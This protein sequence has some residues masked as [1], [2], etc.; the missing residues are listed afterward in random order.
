MKNFKQY[1]RAAIVF[2]CFLNIVSCS[3]VKMLKTYSVGYQS[4]RT[5]HK[6]PDSELEIPKDAEIVVKY[7]ISSNGEL[8]VEVYNMTSSIMIIDQTLSFFVNSDGKSI[9]YFDPTVRT[10]TT[11][12]ITSESSSAAINLGS[13]TR[14]FGIGGIVGQIA[15]GISLGGSK[16]GG[17]VTTDAVYIADQP[18]VSIGPKGSIILSKAFAMKGI[19]KQ[20]LALKQNYVE[21]NTKENI[22]SNKFSVT[23]SYSLDNGVSYKNIIS[24]FFMNSKLIY[25]V[26]SHGDVNK[27]LSKIYESKP[28]CLNEKW[29]MIYFNDNV[30]TLY[31]NYVTGI[32]FD[33]Q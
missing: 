4:V 7:A 16:S 25:Q 3:P 2:S 14:A 5:K 8:L 31:D 27:A 9:S 29:W 33:Y 12:Q 28:D 11:Q 6:Q 17:E 10:I 15:G 19:G 21:L 18:K 24:E 23:I 32:L 30:E 1:L 13:V 26:S 20:S 22:S